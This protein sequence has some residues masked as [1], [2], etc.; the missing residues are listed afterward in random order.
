MVLVIFLLINNLIGIGLGDLLF[1]VMFDGLV[2]WFGEELLCY[3][4]LCGVVFY[5][6]V[7]V[8]LLMVLKY[9]DNDW[10]SEV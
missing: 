1:G 8:L 2:F 6:V 5:L 9:F 3:L 7:V 10:E 4:I